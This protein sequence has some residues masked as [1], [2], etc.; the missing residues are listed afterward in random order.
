M[1][2][3]FTVLAAA[4][5]ALSMLAGGCAKDKSPSQLQPGKKGI[6]GAERKAAPKPR[7]DRKSV[8]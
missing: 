1:R 2:K 7:A 6:A 8:V 3:T 5:F 4:A